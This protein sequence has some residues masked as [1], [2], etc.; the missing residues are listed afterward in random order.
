MHGHTIFVLWWLCGQVAAAPV[1]VVAKTMI[2]AE[3]AEEAV[4]EAVEVV[5]IVGSPGQKQP[6]APKT[7]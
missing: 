2:K 7:I 4:E 6:R 3:V 5:V 1:V